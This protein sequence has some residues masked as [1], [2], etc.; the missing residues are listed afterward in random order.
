MLL[1]A[2][3]SPAERP[4]TLHFEVAGRLENPKIVEASGLA[5]SQREP[6]VLWTINDSGKPY[7]YAIDHEG[8][9]LGRVDL[10]KSDNRDWEDLASF[11]LDGKPYLLVADIGDNDARYKKRT[12][13]IAK[14]P[15]TDENK[16]KVDWEID[17]KYPNGPRDAE[18]VAV[19][20]ENERIL[21]LSKRDIPP[22]LYEL[23]LRSDDDEK[24]TAK[25]LGT[26]ESLP[27]PRRRD[28]ELASK[29]KDWHWQPSGMDISDDNRAAVILTYRAVYY[30]LRREGQGW[31]DALNTKPIR[32]S[33]G[34]FQNAEAVAFA[35]RVERGEAELT[36]GQVHIPTPEPL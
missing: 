34:N 10:N 12:I 26:I 21:V 27:R 19:D 24:V 36:A 32:I 7:L 20:V 2:G 22:A 31:F 29:T 3:C 9:H 11:R 13:Y 1:L 33:L 23:P 35:D 16:T 4:A 14:E 17:F 30:Y 6:G 5:R 18:A 15:R 28:V 25:W 8:Q